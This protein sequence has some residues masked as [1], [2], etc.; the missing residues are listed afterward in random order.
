MHCLKVFQS[1]K[2]KGITEREQVSGLSFQKSS[3]KGQISL[4]FHKMM[5]QKWPL[6]RLH[7][8][9]PL[10]VQKKSATTFRNKFDSTAQA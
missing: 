8:K 1:C 9:G 3:W 10:N 2:R 4:I 6:D 5:V 7:N